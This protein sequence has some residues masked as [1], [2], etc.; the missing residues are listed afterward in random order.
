MKPARRL[1][2]KAEPQHHGASRHP[3]LTVGPLNQYGSRTVARPT[4]RKGLHAGQRA[5]ASLVS[6]HAH[7][8]CIGM[9]APNAACLTPPSYESSGPPCPKTS[10]TR[11]IRTKEIPS[12]QPTPRVTLCHLMYRYG[13]WPGETSLLDIDSCALAL[14]SPG[15]SA[16]M[17]QWWG[18][19]LTCRTFTVH[20]CCCCCAA[21]S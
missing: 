9:A 6:R 15:M 11:G 21:H 18:H 5:T 10:V 12:I 19:V 1:A 20:A 16:R 14:E 4:A 13:Q 17:C 8:E 2:S 3:C 7:H